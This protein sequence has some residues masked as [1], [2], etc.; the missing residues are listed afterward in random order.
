MLHHQSLVRFGTHLAQL[1]T[2]WLQLIFVAQLHRQFY[3]DLYLQTL[4]RLSLHL[5]TIR[6]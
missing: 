2:S 4:H 3:R 5:K 6:Q 1:V